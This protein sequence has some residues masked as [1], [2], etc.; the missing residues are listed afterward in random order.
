[1][2]SPAPWLIAMRMA[3]EAFAD[4]R[5]ERIS[6]RSCSADA[7]VGPLLVGAVD[8]GFPDFGLPAGERFD[9]FDDLARHAADSAHVRVVV[10]AGLLEPADQLVRDAFIDATQQ[11]CLRSVR[12]PTS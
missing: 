3:F 9:R 1:M 11:A 2:C 12:S 8:R 7:D 10:R 5:G 6:Q 4:G